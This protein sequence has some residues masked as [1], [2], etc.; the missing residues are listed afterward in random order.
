MTRR[1]DSA[2]RR[3]RRDV[4][5]YLEHMLEAIGVVESAI[6]GLTLDDYTGDVIVRSAVERQMIIV[7]G[8]LGQLLHVAPGLTA[9]SA[10][11]GA[12]SGFA[13]S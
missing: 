13:M 8:A 6:A 1:E 5:V 2:G 11:R 7:G 4:R 3:R 9:G 10:T 12:L